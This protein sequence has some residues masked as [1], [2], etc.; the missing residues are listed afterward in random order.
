MR[1]QLPAPAIS[2]PAKIA[3]AWETLGQNMLQE[4][5]QELFYRQGHG[6]ALT[7]MRVVLPTKGDVIAIHG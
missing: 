6:T 4:P 1:Q 3:D 2:E 5:A 7:V